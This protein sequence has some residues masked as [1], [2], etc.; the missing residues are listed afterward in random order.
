M[1]QGRNRD[2]FPHMTK[3]ALAHRVG[4]HC[5]NPNCA[6]LTAGP[7]T[8]PQKALNVGVA[9][10]IAAASD[11]GARYDK[12]M[13]ALQ[14]ASIENGIWLCQTCAKLVDNDAERYTVDLLRKWKILAEE[15]A[16]LR[17]EGAGARSRKRK[18]YYVI[19]LTEEQRLEDIACPTCCEIV[20]LDLS[21]LP[22]ASGSPLCPKCGYFHVSRDA[23]GEI[24]IRQWGGSVHKDYINCPNCSN[25]LRVRTDKKLL[26]KPCLDCES[27]LQVNMGQVLSIAPMKAIDA[28]SFSKEGWKQLLL[29]PNCG[30]RGIT[31]GANNNDIL[32]AHCP[33]CR[34]YLKFPKPLDAAQSERKDEP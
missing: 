31:L 1:T 10:H 17:V 30:V 20:K 15:S 32:F 19:T 29:C 26:S 33:K 14:R 34:Y 3:L 12:T 16:R 2:D 18:R 25:R 13:T 28:A 24:L 11:G 21:R 27:I 7:Q 23:D 5:S 8:D 4:V 6:K 22:G 9:A